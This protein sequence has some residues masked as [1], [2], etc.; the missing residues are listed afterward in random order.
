MQHK[1]TGASLTHL[2]CVQKQAR[3]SVHTL[4]KAS[5]WHAFQEAV[6]TARCTPA[7]SVCSCAVCVCAFYNG[8]YPRIG[9]V[10]LISHTLKAVSKI[11]YNVKNTLDLDLNL[12]RH[13]QAK[14]TP[15]L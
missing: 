10:I 13:S 3:G 8:F 11:N 2:P 4:G 1:H 7:H 12:P 9:L 6:P 14:S 5:H 15:L